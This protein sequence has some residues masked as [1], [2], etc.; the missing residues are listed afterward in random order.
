MGGRLPDYMQDLGSVRS[1]PFSEKVV[2]GNLI[3]DKEDISIHTIERFEEEIG[4]AKTILLA[5]IRWVNLKKKVIDRGQVEWSMQLSIRMLSK[6]QVAE[7]LFRQSKH[8][9]WRKDL[10]TFLLQE[11]RCLNSW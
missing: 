6:L 9:N 1:V 5:D 8:L 10:I 4:K 11:V 3:M 2:P 7:I